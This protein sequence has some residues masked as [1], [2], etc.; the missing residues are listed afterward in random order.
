M[1]PAKWPISGL[2]SAEYPMISVNLRVPAP[3]HVRA[4]AGPRRATPPPQGI[5]AT[6]PFFA[7]SGTG[8]VS[9]SRRIVTICSSVNR[10]F[11]MTPS[12]SRGR[13]SLKRQLARKSPGTSVRRGCSSRAGRPRRCP[14]T[15]ATSHG[16]RPSTTHG[17]RGSAAPRPPWG[18]GAFSQHC[19]H[20]GTFHWSTSWSMHRPSSK[21]WLSRRA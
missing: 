12:A 10:V 16:S 15:R 14:A 18:T 20:H 3:P 9:A 4:T 2:L 1:G 11:F 7:T 21:S 17:D 6:T 8:L 5:H 19:R 13:H